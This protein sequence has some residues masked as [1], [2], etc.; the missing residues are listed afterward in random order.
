MMQK[1]HD[2]GQ[3]QALQSFEARVRPSPIVFAVALRRRPLPQH[4]VSD[5]TDAEGG[6]TIDIVE[7]MR[8]TATVELIIPS[9]P[10]AAD[11]ALDARPNLQHSRHAT[12]DSALRRPSV[13][14]PATTS[15][16]MFDTMM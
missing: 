15:C 1:P 12:A 11:R 10:D 9:V 3:R 8:V 14:R 2:R 5:P 16:R 13:E 6:E 7:S 4:G